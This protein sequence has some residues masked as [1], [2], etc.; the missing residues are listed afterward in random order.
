MIDVTL[1]R[2]NPAHVQ[3]ALA[4]RAVYVDL[5]E[6]LRLDDDYRQMRAEVER[7]RG[8]RKRISAEIARRQRIGEDVASLHGDA[9]S[10][11]EHL[12]TAETRLTELDQARQAFLDPLPNLPD[13]DVPAGARRT[14]R[15]SVKQYSAQGSVSRPRTTWSSLAHLA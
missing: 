15:S 8:E 6:F 4:K 1:I 9:T 2:Q 3:Q 13:A 11:G 10:V 7:L 12:T 14:T 5:D